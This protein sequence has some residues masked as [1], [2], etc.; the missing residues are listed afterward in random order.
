MSDIENGYK[1]LAVDPEEL[2]IAHRR[3][4][5]REQRDALRALDRAQMALESE[6]AIQRVRELHK[7]VKSLSGF[8][9]EACEACSQLTSMAL[10]YENWVAYGFC[11]T[12]KAL[13]GEQ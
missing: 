2:A 3:K 10:G 7:P 11:P 1:K 6:A 4:I 9:P 8:G 13:D 5:V 12:I